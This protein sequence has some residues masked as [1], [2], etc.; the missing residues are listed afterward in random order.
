MEKLNIEE[1][2]I[3][4]ILL[5]HLMA[6]KNENAFLKNN[7]SLFQSE[8]D[9]AE[10][11]LG[12]KKLYG[13]KVKDDLGGIQLNSDILNDNLGG[14][15]LN[16]G[17]PKDD[18]GVIQLKTGISENNLGGIPVTE[19]LSKLITDGNGSDLLYKIFEK[20]LRNALEDYIKNGDGQN[21]LYNFYNDFEDA[22]NEQNSAAAKI[23]EAASNARLEDTHSLP[24]QLNSDKDSIINFSSKLKGTLARRA[25]RDSFKTVA[26][27]LLLLHNAG[28]ATSSELRGFSG[29]SVKGFEKHLQKMLHYNLVKKQ[30]PS[31]YVLTEKSKHILLELFGKENTK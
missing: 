24:A 14:I 12:G 20:G 22:V 15:Q 11:D 17:I 30:P 10:T 26:K 31:N 28:K 25:D 9:I 7:I 23:K 1:R 29:L 8:V 21:T 5:K 2:K 16:K 4:K 18:L 3:I 27:E 6:L 13:G 19:A